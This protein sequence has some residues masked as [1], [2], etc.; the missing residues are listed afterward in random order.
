MD[1]RV[2]CA[3]PTLFPRR[4]FFWHPPICQPGSAASCPPRLRQLLREPPK[5]VRGATSPPARSRR[6]GNRAGRPVLSSRK[7]LVLL[8]H[9][10]ISPFLHPCI[11]VSEQFL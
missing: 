1:P 4:P 11:G 5:R 2:P 6:P 8:V 9:P 3:A 7:V 10:W